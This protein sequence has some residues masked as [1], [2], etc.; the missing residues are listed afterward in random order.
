M[1]LESELD[2]RW[3]YWVPQPLPE[4][5]IASAPACGSGHFLAGGAGAVLVKKPFLASPPG[6]PGKPNSTM[7]P[8]SGSLRSS[9]NSS[10]LDNLL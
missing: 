10:Y 6:K 5:A 8:K 1:P 3:K 4:E 7:L 2:E 9:R